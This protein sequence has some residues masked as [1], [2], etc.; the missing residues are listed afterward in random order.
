M[1]CRN[2]GGNSG[3]N[4]FLVA[5]ALASSV[6]QKALEMQAVCNDGA[7]CHRNRLPGVMYR[8]RSLGSPDRFLTGVPSRSQTVEC[9]NC[10][11]V[12]PIKAERRHYEFDKIGV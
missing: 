11:M 4:M 12:K 9:Y 8:Y 7:I 5:K 1:P 2:R 10:A 3:L 6:F